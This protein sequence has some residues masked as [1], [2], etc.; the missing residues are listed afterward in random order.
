LGSL[1][2]AYVPSK[3]PQQRLYDVY[4][5]SLLEA[6]HMTLSNEDHKFEQL[7]QAITPHSRLLRRWALKGG[8]SA[9]MTALELERP[10]GRTSRMI[11]RRPGA[12]ILKHNPHAA[13][14]EFKLLQLTQSLGLA[15]PTPY[16]LDQSGTIFSTPYVVIEYIEGQPEFA[17]AHLADFTLQLATQ[18]AKIHRVDCAN[19]DVSFL[20]R[21]ANGCAETFGSRPT[22]VD[23]SLDE[24]RIRDMLE[25]A[26]PLPR[27]NAPVLLHG[28]FWPGNFLWRD[29][30][31]VAVIDWEDATVGD[32]LTDLAISRL[33]ILWIFG[34]D[35]MNSFTEQYQSMMAID[36]SNLPYWD[37]CA[38]L[39]LVRLA[40]ADLAEWAAFFPPFGRHDITEQTI[41]E[42]YR[43]FITQAFEKFAVEQARSD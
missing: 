9:E 12:G 41:R 10:D 3:P 19:L 15:T 13:Q 11:V 33:D 30:Q 16:Y 39:R 6:K 38:A 25:S 40:G 22:N 34:T 31:L 24:G 35:A 1:G 26:W 28:D 18:L 27:R 5:I 4:L 32:P 21:R 20:A 29:E 8:I 36:Y 2:G 14:D 7:V 23:T 37:L 17:P 43:F 42:H